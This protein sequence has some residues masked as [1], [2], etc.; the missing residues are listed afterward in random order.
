[1][2]RQLSVKSYFKKP[3]ISDDGLDKRGEKRGSDALEEGPATSVLPV[4]P[5]AC[6]AATGKDGGKEVRR[7]YRVQW[8]SEF[9]W[10][11]VEEGKMFCDICRRAKVT[12]GFVR[13]CKNRR[14]MT[15]KTAKATSEH[16][17]RLTKVCRWGST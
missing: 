13:G 10:L 15:T 6:A 14:S 16:V 1:M 17:Q 4:A 5:A 11:R 3:T 12:N 9:T 7:E 2:S 8:E